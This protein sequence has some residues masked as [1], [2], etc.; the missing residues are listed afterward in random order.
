MQ[1]KEKKTAKNNGWGVLLTQTVVCAVVLLFALILRLIGGGVFGWFRGTVNGA[2]SDDSLLTGLSSRI[3]GTTVTTTTTVQPMN[4]ESTTT[5]ADTTAT[6][7]DGTTTPA[8]TTSTTAATHA[9]G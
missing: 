7:T 9:D 8:A 4:I 2:L 5:V 3:Y 1:E 6:G